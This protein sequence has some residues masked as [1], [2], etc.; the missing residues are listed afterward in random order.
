MNKNTSTFVVLAIFVAGSIEAARLP[1]TVNIQ[2]SGQ[3]G[4]PEIVPCCGVFPYF[5][6]SLFTNGHFGHSDFVLYFASFPYFA[7]PYCECL[8]YLLNRIAKS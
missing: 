2:N 7:V 6:S 4:C 3:V 1:G 8:R 5:A